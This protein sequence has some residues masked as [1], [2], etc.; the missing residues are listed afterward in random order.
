MK[1]K[2]EKLSGPAT[3]IVV[4]PLGDKDIVFTIQCVLDYSD[5]EKM[6]PEPKPPLIL[7]RGETVQAPNLEDS[8]YRNEINKYYSQQTKYMILKSLE[9]TKD[10]EF[11]SVKLN[12]PSTWDNFDKEMQEAGFTNLH[13]SRLIRE[14]S[15][16]NGLDERKIDEAKQRFLAMSAQQ[17]K[18][19][20]P[21]AV[22]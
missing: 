8:K 16:I 5:F 15:A 22:Q 11:E 21:Q 10:L 6:V 4:I 2:N 13:I 1:Y 9:P 12:D 3:T 20:F 7:R 18:Q 19:P 17:E 14:I